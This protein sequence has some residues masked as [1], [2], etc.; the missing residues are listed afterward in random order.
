VLINRDNNTWEPEF[1]STDP[2]GFTNWIKRRDELTGNEFRRVVRLMKYLKRE[3]GSFNGVRSVILTTLLG[4]QVTEIDAAN[5]SRFA[6][7]PTALVK[8]VEAL[9]EWLQARQVMPS[10]ANPN[11]DGTT[12]D[13]RWTPETYANFRDR[14]HT[15]AADMRNAYDEPDAEKSVAAWQKLFGDD[16][17]PPVAKST[18]KASNPFAATA[19][20]AAATIGSSRSGRAG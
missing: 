8:V 9:D 6:N 14:I 2:Q 1:G 18:S 13:H 10:I 3:R 16:F 17:T 20:A 15:I 4:E 12:F 11:G 5:P 19:G 7:L